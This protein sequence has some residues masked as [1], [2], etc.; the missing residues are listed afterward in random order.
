MLKKL[1]EKM[2]NIFKVENNQ[3]EESNVSYLLTRNFKLI[4]RA[5]TIDFGSIKITYTISRARKTKNMVIVIALSDYS[6]L[7]E[8]LK[9]EKNNMPIFSLINK[10]DSIPPRFDFC[11]DSQEDGVFILKIPKN[12]YERINLGFPEI[13]FRSYVTRRLFIENNERRKN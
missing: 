13:R 3:D 7:M 10:K 5:D 6:K 1:Y 4:K 12:D 9:L 2:K 11:P 8:D